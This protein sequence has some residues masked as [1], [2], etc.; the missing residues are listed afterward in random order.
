MVTTV[1]PHTIASTLMGMVIANAPKING[2][3]DKSIHMNKSD[4]PLAFKTLIFK[5]DNGVNIRAKQ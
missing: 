3:L 5:A 4:L 2:A 1:L